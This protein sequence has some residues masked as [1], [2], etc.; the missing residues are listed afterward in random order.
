M[1]NLT[2]SLIGVLLSRAGLNRAVRH[3]TPLLVLAANAPD[4]D[5]VSYFL[6]PDAQGY[7]QYHRGLTHAVIGT[8]LVAILPVVVLRLLYRKDPVSWL[9]AWLVSMIGVASHWLLDFTNPYG[10]RLW[11][12]FSDNW[13]ALD[14]TSVV[15]IWIWTVLLFA[16]LWPMLARLVGSEIG[17]R[18]GIGRGWAIT[19]L[20][21]VL[22]Y[23]TGKSFL[24]TRA[25]AIQEARIYNGETPRRV[26]ALPTPFNPFKWQGLVETRAFWVEQIVDLSS[27]FDPAHGIIWY[28]P[29]ASPA[30]EA[31]RKTS[32]FRVL[33]QFSRALT[34]RVTP[35]SEIEGGTLVEAVDLRFKFTASALI[36][37]QG[38]VERSSLT[39]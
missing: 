37:A 10:I 28:K 39:F 36:D 17:A 16:V 23:N 9:R 35:S 20:L 5:V 30:V 19:G 33:E 13:P 6:A 2:H 26:L 11:L 7:L 1:D 31:A 24:H 4:C 21:F 27:E 29:A 14:T 38:I 18:T 8:P 32:S 12:P 22:L 3:A 25:V 15:D 34:L